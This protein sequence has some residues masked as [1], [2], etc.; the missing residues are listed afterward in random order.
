MASNNLILTWNHDLME[1]GR[2]RVCDLLTSW[3]A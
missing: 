1:F 2:K 3:T